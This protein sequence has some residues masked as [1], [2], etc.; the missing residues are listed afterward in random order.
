MSEVAVREN[1]TVSVLRQLSKK[2]GGDAIVAGERRISGSEAVTTVL[3]FAA[4]IRG[5]GL[6]A[7]DGVALF[8]ENTPE[9][10][11]LQLAV[12]FVG[13][14]LVLVP[15]GLDN[16]ELEALVARA[17]VKMLLFDPAFAERT[18]R[19]AERIDVPH[20]FSIGASPIAADFLAAAADKTGLPLEEAADGRHIA[21]LL[22]TSGTTGLPKLVLQR[23]GHYDAI[24]SDSSASVDSASVDGAS[25]DDASASP[26]ALNCLPVTS[27]SGHGAFLADILIGRV[28]VLLRTFEAGRAL[29]AMETEHVT[30]LTVTTPMLYEL[31]DHPDCRPGRFPALELLTYTGAPA[32]PTRL[33]QAI[34]RFGPVL[35]QLYGTTESGIVTRLIPQ[36]HDLEQRASLSSCGRPVLGVELELRDNDGKPVPPGQPGELYLRSRTVMAGYWNE[37]ERTAAALDEQG[38]LRSGDI[39]RQDENG[40]LYLLGRARETTVTDHDTVSASPAAFDDFGVPPSPFPG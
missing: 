33:R 22:T 6:A 10:L 31:L 4:V 1:Y 21:T 16:S 13:G 36:E 7:G 30:A 20:R 18:E 39:A 40:Y 37:P 24:A 11:L 26:A 23:G 8:M 34:E 14:R 2:D 19:I 3:R 29:S 12:H 15:P 32:S 38:W 25:A 5:S 17:D 28:I 35:Q 9:A 27:G